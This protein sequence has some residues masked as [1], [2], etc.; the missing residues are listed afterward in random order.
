[1]ENNTLYLKI[2]PCVIG[3]GELFWNIFP[4]K[5]QTG[6]ESINFVLQASKIGTE[7][8]IVSAV[9]NDAD[10]RA[11]LGRLKRAKLNGVIKMNKFKIGISYVNC[12][13]GVFKY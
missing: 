4:E 13:D 2:K 5:R 11:I 3:V 8:Y 9:G 1:M 6:G 7:S 10:G 12:Y